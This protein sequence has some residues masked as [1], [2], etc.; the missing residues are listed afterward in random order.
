MPGGKT[1]GPS[2]KK[3]KVYEALREEGYSKE[4]AAKTSNSQARKGKK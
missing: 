3:P 2:I 1:P 4:R